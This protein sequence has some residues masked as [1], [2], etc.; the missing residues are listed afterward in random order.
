MGTKLLDMIDYGKL[1]DKTT[2]HTWLYTLLTGLC[3]AVSD[4]RTCR[5][6]DLATRHDTQSST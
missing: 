6:S 5:A 2:N 1:I 3:H 4:I